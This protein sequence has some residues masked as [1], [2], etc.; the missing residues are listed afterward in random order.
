MVLFGIS[1]FPEYLRQL[2]KDAGGAM[3]DDLCQ[4]LTFT[5]LHNKWKAGGQA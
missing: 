2:E 3:L 1:Q 4:D 5:H